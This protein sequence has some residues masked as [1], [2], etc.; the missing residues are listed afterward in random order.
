MNRF[1]RGE[2]SPLE[3]RALAQEALDDPNLFDELT[4]MSVGR[5][6]LSKRRSKILKWPWI[7]LAGV[8][9]AVAL[10][11]LLPTLRRTAKPVTVAVAVAREPILLA[12]NSDPNSAVFRGAESDGRAPRALGSVVSVADGQAAFDLGSLDGLAK[13]GRVDVMHD[14]KPVGTLAVTTVFRERAR[15]D[16]SPG[17]KLHAGDQVR[18]PDAAYLGALLDQIDAL[19]ARGDSA[20]ARRMADEAS[21]L[22]ADSDASDYAGLNNLAVIAELRGEKAKARSFYQRALAANP[23]EA[24]LLSIAGNLARVEGAK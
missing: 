10:V 14:G 20:G 1:A 17:L 22:A 3:A 12:R 9:A 2:L 16:A 23:P 13:G 4:A 15:G 21:H 19:S 18:V 5:A 11:A 7:A 6:G 8:A 24:A